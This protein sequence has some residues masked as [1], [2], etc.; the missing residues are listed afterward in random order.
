MCPG[1]RGTVT[2]SMA[3]PEPLAW[4]ETA[5][6]PQGMPGAAAKETAAETRE[7]NPARQGAR[8]KRAWSWVTR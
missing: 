1:K 7:R 5:A 2:P 4:S 3:H 6:Q 8:G